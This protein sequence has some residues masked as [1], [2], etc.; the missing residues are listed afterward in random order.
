MN[1]VLGNILGEKLK[2]DRVKLRGLGIQG[3]DNLRGM[4]IVS[5]LMFLI[6]AI[7][8]PLLML[9]KYAFIDVN[10]EFVGLANFREYFES[11][12]LVN[13]IKNTLYISIT[14]TLV[15]MV[16]SF[17]YAYGIKRTCIKG[18][19]YYN[20]IMLLPLFAPT[21]M[22]GIS[23]V[24][25]FGRQG[26]LTKGFFGHLPFTIELPLYG[27]LGIIIS[28]VI[29]TLPQTYLL[30]SIALSMADY[31]LYE[32]ADTL[33]ASKIKKF[34][35]ITLPSIKYGAVSAF[36]VAFVL[37]FTDFGA[38]KV[39]GGNY[40]VLATDIYKQVVGQHN[41]TMG[42]VVSIVLMIPA[43]ISFVADN[44]IQKQQRGSYNAKSKVYVNKKDSC[45]DILFQIYCTIVSSLI[46]VIIGTVVVASLVKTWPYNLSVTLAN[47][48]FS[49]LNGSSFDYYKTSVI[50][51]TITAVTGTIIVFTASYLTEKTKGYKLIRKVSY[52]LA[53]I[54]LTLPGLVIGISYILFFN[55]PSFDILG[56][57][58]LNPFN[59]IY[60]TWGIMVLANLIHFFSVSFLTANTALKKLDKEFEEVGESLSVPWYKTFIW[61]SIPLSLDAILEIF[62]YIFVNSMVAVSALVFIYTSKLTPASV[63]M[64][65]LDDAGETAKAAA[66]AV[67]IILTNMLVKFILNGV[68]KSL[69]KR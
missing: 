63:A 64:I 21:M 8:L 56:I 60:G 54:P 19:K 20:Y 35:T 30:L 40:N 68:R 15:S 25:L 23:L 24:Y 22:H 53:L 7:V 29:F 3:A 37:S 12:N 67:L 57:E 39:V 2:V 5:L 9:L 44:Y 14:S 4:L 32:A 49:N 38:P 45:V 16:L 10:N 48:S 31:N 11:G 1:A 50:I 27:S 46:L 65:N 43:I 6:I 33:G 58:V 52:I 26:L 61:V 36:F 42:A 34:F 47:F 41:I 17:F 62:T 51:A 28:E 66:I 55:R 59:G 69:I 18:K 13:S